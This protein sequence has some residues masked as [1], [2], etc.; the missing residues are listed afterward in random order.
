[1]IGNDSPW[2]DYLQD[3]HRR[4]PDATSASLEPFLTTDGKTSYRLL[5]ETL[6][7]R[8]PRAAG[9]RVLDLGCGDGR[10]SRELIG[11]RGAAV[12]PFGLD[13]SADEIARAHAR[14]LPETFVRG[15]AQAM[16][17]PDAHFNAVLS[18]FAFM[19]M[20]PIE[21]V[22]RELERVLEPNGLFAAALSRLSEAGGDMADVLAL[23]RK[24][25][26]GKRHPAI[27]PFDPR[28][29]TA[30]GIATLFRDAGSTRT[31]SLRSE[32]V[33]CDADAKTALSYLANLYFFEAID[34]QAREILRAD[35][36]RLAEL[37]GGRLILA[38]T[39]DI[40]ALHPARPI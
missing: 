3:F 36:E 1:M 12:R 39:I 27:P 5:A 6:D 10:L 40:I 7:E 25:N 28:Q 18:H 11:L 24:A 14:G 16:P 20:V 13:L 21:S 34:A 15:S 2:D 31:M 19:L 32:L 4:L 22:V 29:S 26:G 33:T 37:R 35:I 30:A 38:Q 8:L 17:F 23:F 9:V